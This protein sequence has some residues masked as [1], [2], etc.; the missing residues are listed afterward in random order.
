MNFG[1]V[2]IIRVVMVGAGR[3]GGADDRLDQKDRAGHAAQG[4][5]LDPVPSIEIGLIGAAR[6]LLPGY[7]R[8]LFNF[9]PIQHV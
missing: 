9:T 5:H 1:L 7:S 3:A 4:S 2:G 6:C 8:G